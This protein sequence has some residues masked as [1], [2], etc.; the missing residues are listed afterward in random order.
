MQ[1]EH[2]TYVGPCP[3]GEGPDRCYNQA[4]RQVYF[5]TT[6]PGEASSHV[7]EWRCREHGGVCDMVTAGQIPNLERYSAAQRIDADRRADKPSQDHETVFTL[8][9]L[10]SSADLR[11]PEKCVLRLVT[12][13]CTENTNG[14][15]VTRALVIVKERPPK[16]PKSEGPYR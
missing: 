5:D 1:C 6:I 10:F 7:M 12:Q 11:H 2:T 4:L 13:L 16:P 8:A 15:L 14:Q 9:E 3:D